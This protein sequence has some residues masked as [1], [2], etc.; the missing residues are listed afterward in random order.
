MLTSRQTICRWLK[1]GAILV[2]IILVVT[3]CWSPGSQTVRTDAAFT[4]S[5]QPGPTASTTVTLIP[6]IAAARQVAAEFTQLYLSYSWDQPS[7]QAEAFQPLVTA[8]LLDE[9]T[10]NSS[11]S[12]GQADLASRQEVGVAVADPA[13][14]EIHLQDGT[15]TAWTY[16]Q[17]TVTYIGGQDH[18]DLQ[19]TLS[20]V[21]EKDTWLVATVEL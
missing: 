1:I 8:P 12:A 19:L 15:V 3:V 16:A 18:H 5:P 6:D 7:L 9:L 13:E 11:A 17:L 4:S 21:R 20:L 10:T 2:A 14:V